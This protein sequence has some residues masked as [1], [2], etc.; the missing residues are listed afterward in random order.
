MAGKRTD[1]KKASPPHTPTQPGN[2]AKARLWGL[3]NPGKVT[4]HLWDLKASVLANQTK[5]KAEAYDSRKVYKNTHTHLS[6]RRLG[7]LRQPSILWGTKSA[8]TAPTCPEHRKK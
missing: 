2:N 5:I 7:R 3:Q 8:V 4:N 6:G 1:L